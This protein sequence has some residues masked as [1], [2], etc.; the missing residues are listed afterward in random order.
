M[1]RSVAGKSQPPVFDTGTPTVAFVPPDGLKPWRGE[2]SP[3]EAL[4]S[5]ASNLRQPVLTKQTAR[6]IGLV[7][8]EPM[9]DY[10]FGLPIW[11]RTESSGQRDANDDDWLMH[12][13][14]TS[15][16]RK[17]FQISSFSNERCCVRRSALECCPTC[18]HIPRLSRMTKMSTSE[19]KA[20]LA[21][22]K[23]DALAALSA[24]RLAEERADAMDYYLGDMRKDMPAQDGR[25]RAVSTDVADTI[26][27]LMPS[28][29]D[30]FAGSDE[31]V[32]FEPVGPEDEA[33]AQQETDYVNHV[34]MQQNP[35]FMTLYSFIKDALL[36][37][38]V[39]SERFGWASRPRSEND[40]QSAEP[41]DVLGHRSGRLGGQQNY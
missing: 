16:A 11:E 29:M 37:P 10:L 34:F 28:L 8:G 33:A 36:L 15:V 1:A 39:F 5:G 17:R 2:Q 12:L 40:S 27:G 13:F 3:R 18:T 41:I 9:P 24:A 6:P 35:G 23:A 7:S 14:R 21:S 20:M 31:V 38:R 30:I 26:E 19:L 4:A 32:R 25:S 22:E